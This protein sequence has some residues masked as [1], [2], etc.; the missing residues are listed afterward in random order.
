LSQKLATQPCIHPIVRQN[1]RRIIEDKYLFITYYSGCI[2][3]GI[4]LVLEDI[5]K[6]QWV[7]ETINEAKSNIKF[8]IGHHKSQAFFKKNS[9]K[10]NNLELLRPRDIQFGTNFIM[11]ERL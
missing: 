11:L 1:A 3:H 6:T 2:A 10:E 8:I 7:H 5:E 9:S 4:D